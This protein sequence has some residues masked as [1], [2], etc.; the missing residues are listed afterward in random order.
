MTK[1]NIHT[2]QAPAAIGPYVQAV[3][4]NDL[5]YTA[6]QGGLDPVTGNL[7]E[8]G[9]EAQAK[10][11]MQN[12]AAVLEAAGSDFNHVIKTNIFLRYIKDFGAVNQVYATFFDGQFPARSTVAVNALPMAALV[13]IEMVALVKKTDHEEIIKTPSG[14]ETVTPEEKKI[15]KKEGSQ[16]SKKTKKKNKEIKV[17]KEKSKEIRSKNEN[18]L[19]RRNWYYQFCLHPISR[20]SR[21]RPFPAQSRS[22]YQT[23][24]FTPRCQSA[25]WRYS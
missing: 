5:I 19:H 12:L 2:D 1:E 17:Q 15:S 7:V 14:V 11:T 10:Q 21:H 6:G 25:Q 4:V 13:E 8:G 3:R 18:S 24:T 22:D 16:I 23:W 20:G 9:V